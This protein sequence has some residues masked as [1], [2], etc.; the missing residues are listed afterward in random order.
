MNGVREW[1]CLPQTTGAVG[2]VNNG[3]ATEYGGL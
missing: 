1:Q 3:I 2:E